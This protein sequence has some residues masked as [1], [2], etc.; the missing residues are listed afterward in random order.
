MS[1]EYLWDRS[2]SAGSRDRA[3]RAS[4]RQVAIHPARARMAGQSPAD[5]RGSLS[6]RYFAT[7]AALV[8][9]CTAGVWSIRPSTRVAWPVVRVAGTPTVNET[10]GAGRRPAGRRR[11]ARDGQE[12]ACDRGDRRCRPPRCRT[13]LTTAAAGRNDRQSSAVDGT[14][15]G[16]RVHLGASRASS[17]SRPRPPRWSTSDA[18]TR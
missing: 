18:R 10:Q 16:A 8:A 5:E 3:A 6:F 4:A 17:S 1:D 7:A 2:G 14:R 15:D 13:R 12:L 9:A 11:V